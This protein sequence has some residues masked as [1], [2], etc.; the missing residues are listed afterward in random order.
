ML[1]TYDS[2]GKIIKL[3]EPSSTSHP[4]YKDYLEN[5]KVSRFIGNS[6]D[7]VKQH[8]KQLLSNA[9]FNMSESQWLE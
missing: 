7:E 1:Y 3:K 9:K 8:L 4:K 2:K 6:V 5:L